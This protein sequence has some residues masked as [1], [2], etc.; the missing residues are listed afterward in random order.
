MGSAV[1]R[2]LI[3][4]GHQVTGLARS[5]AAGAAVQA[6]GAAVHHGGL[7]TGQAWVITARAVQSAGAA[8]AAPAALALIAV[9]FPRGPATGTVPWRCARRWRRGPRAEADRCRQLTQDGGLG[10]E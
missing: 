6:A 9:N 8:M 3:Q 7:A 4:A 10:L 2:E 1:V 5:Q